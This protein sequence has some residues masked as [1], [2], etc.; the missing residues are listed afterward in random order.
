M[1]VN[2]KSVLDFLNNFIVKERL[3]KSQIIQL[4]DI[5]IVSNDI[6]DLEENLKWE[7][8]IRKHKI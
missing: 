4:A 5:A 2:D 7:S 8:Y 6:R 3:N 1:R